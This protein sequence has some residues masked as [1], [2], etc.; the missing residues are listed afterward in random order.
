MNEP[1]PPF[2]ER[3]LSMLRELREDL[4]D[5]AARVKDFEDDDKAQGF[6]DQIVAVD[7]R[8]DHVRDATLSNL[9]ELY[10]GSITHHQSVFMLWL[11]G[12][13]PAKAQA[14][15]EYCQRASSIAIERARNASSPGD[16]EADF[17]SDL[18][19]YCKNHGLPFFMPQS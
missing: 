9:R 13:S 10:A 19:T 7:K 16:V 8:V 6:Q 5:L 3:V 15:R 1:D 18:T 12:T 4:N 2:E 11:I 14:A 17:L